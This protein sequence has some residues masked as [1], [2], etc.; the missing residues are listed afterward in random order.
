MNIGFYIDEMNLRGVANSTYSY[1]LNNKNILKN[2]SII[3]YNKKNYRNNSEVI[4][5]FK[6]KFISIGISKFKEIDLYKSKFNLNYIYTQKSGNKDCWVSNNIKTLVHAVYPQKLN[7]LHGHRYAYISEWLSVKFSNKKIPFIPYITE[8]KKITSNLRNRLKI[9]KDNLV[10]GCHGGESS[11]DMKFVQF[12]ILNVLKKRKDIFFLFLN[13]DKFC[14]HPRIIFLKGTSDEN[15]KKKFINSCDAMIYGRSLGESFGLACAEF[16]VKCKDII[17]YQFNRHQCHKFYMP[18]R[19]YL[20][21]RSYKTLY[22][23]LFNYVKKPKNKYFSKY[24][25]YTSKR[26]MRNFEKFFLIQKEQIKISL[27][28]KFINFLNYLIMNYFYLRH[29]LYSHYFNH[30]YSK[31]LIK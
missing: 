17:S 8:S 19:N 21:Y 4:K 29:K 7:Q 23:L 12:A 9:K 10:F 16:A 14:T 30:F 22:N 18:K 15:Y 2:N 24:Q 20:E 5:K 25:K 1:A 27:F 26:A 13:I 28:D 3:F 11:F 31:F 6:K